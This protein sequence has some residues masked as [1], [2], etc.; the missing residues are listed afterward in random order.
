MDN[1]KTGMYIRCSIDQEF[2]DEPRR[3]AM[4]QITNID[5]IYNEISVCFYGEKG[6]LKAYEIDTNKKYFAEEVIRSE[7]KQ[8]TVVQVGQEEAEIIGSLADTKDGYYQYFISTKQKEQQKVLVISEQ[9]ITAP[10]SAQDISPMKQFQNYEFHNPIWYQHRQ[11]VMNSIQSLRNATFGF[12]TLIGSRVFLMPHQ[13]DTIIRVLSEKQCRFMLADEV[14]LGKTIEAAVIKKGLQQRIYQLKVIILAPESLTY[15]WR[16][17]LSY[18]FWEDI[19]VWEDETTTYDDQIIFPIEKVNTPEGRRILNENWDLSI[20]DET[21]RLLKAPAIYETL[22]AF[23]RRVPHLLLLTATP[24]QYRRLEYLKLLALLEPTK[25]IQMSETEFEQLLDKQSFISLKIHA[26]VRDLDDYYR[27]ELAEDYV[28]DLEEIAEELSDPILDDLVENIDIE[29]DDEGYL[30]VQL[31]MAYIAE[32]YQIERKIIRHRRK[33]LENQLQPRELDTI[34]YTFSGSNQGFYELETYET[35]LNYLEMITE[36]SNEDTAIGEYIQLYLSAMFSSAFALSSVI[37]KRMH[38]LSGDRQVERTGIDHVIQTIPSFDEEGS[39]LE[40][41]HT[42]TNQWVKASRSEF[43]RLEELYDDPDLI[44]GR[45]MKVIDYLSESMSNKFIIFTS[46]TETL[47]PLKQVL[48]K[49]FGEDS[50]RSFHK[51]LDETTL[52]QNASD[53]QSMS[54]VRFMICDELGGEGRNFQMADEVI[55]IDLPWSP[56][57]LEQRIGRLDRIGRSKEVVSVV[58]YAMDCLDEDLFKLWESGLNIFHES[59]SGLEIALGDIKEN[60]QEALVQNLRYGMESIIEKM[61]ESLQG[62][63]KRVEQERYFDMARQLDQTVEEH[64][65]TLIDNFDGANGKKLG[66]T[67]M[68]WSSLA[69]L[70]GKYGEDGNITVFDSGNVSIKSMK[71]TLF[72]P[73]DMKEAHKRAKRTGEIRGTFD[74]NYAIKREDLVFYAPGDP[75]FDAII[76]NASQSELGRSCAFIKTDSELDWKGMLLTW[77]VQIDPVPLFNLGES[78]ENLMA[79]Q[80][81]LPLEPITHAI[82]YDEEDNAPEE[83]VREVICNTH[84]NGKSLHHLGKRGNGQVDVFKERFDKEEWLIQTNR[85]YEESYQKLKQQ[86]KQLIDIDRAKMD[87]QQKIHGLQASNLYYN[88]TNQENSQELKRLELIYGAIMQGLENP[89]ITLES[90]A[91][92]WL[93]K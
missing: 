58:P 62:M 49:K 52:Q 71:N 74:R 91:F 21:H 22:L 75:F 34:P 46:W 80:G 69:G 81:Y 27:D 3:F 5:P 40:G 73:P 82:G 28:D 65:L 76:N 50:V 9:H 31:A 86:L 89:K 84:E 12:E 44:N 30:D 66:D 67:M 93:K 87:F 68:A 90:I 41:L 78:S 64:L 60:I 13:V 33:E 54:Q 85:A 38:F 51:G 47:H 56:S 45:L 42:V 8:N 92:A 36:Q 88:R 6:L 43:N 29:S 14:G 79:A 25:Y 37:E 59:L 18:K 10:F 24:I 2:P 70:R 23:S 63:R 53:F 57:Q 35:L 17:E 61:H 48:I 32:H 72:V 7:I 20:V 83:L 39:L 11:I 1:L 15:Q 77:S 4:G 19:P 26:L 16:N 55:H